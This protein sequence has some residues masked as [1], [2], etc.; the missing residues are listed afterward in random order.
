[1]IVSGSKIYFEDK[2]VNI[3]YFS[4]WKNEK[5]IFVIVTAGAGPSV[6]AAHNF[7]KSARHNLHSVAKSERFHQKLWASVN[8]FLQ[9]GGLF[10]SDKIQE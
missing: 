8:L 4:P 10:I 1:M 2:E 7:P 5:I 6:V 9:G 3:N